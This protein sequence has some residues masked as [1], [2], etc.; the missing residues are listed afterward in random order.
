MLKALDLV[1]HVKDKRSAG[2]VK[3]EVSLK[4]AYGQR[5]L[6]AGCLEAPFAGFVCAAGRQDTLV[7]KRHDPVG[8]GVTGLREIPE[9]EFPDD[10]AFNDCD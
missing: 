4:P 3:A 8:M 10:A 5:P 2:E 1:P 7:D 6:Q 9:G